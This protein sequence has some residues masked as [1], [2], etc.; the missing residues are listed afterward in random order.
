MAYRDLKESQVRRD[1]INQPNIYK[2][3]SGQLAQFV[4]NEELS[5]SEHTVHGNYKSSWLRKKPLPTF[6]TQHKIARNSKENVRTKVGFV[7]IIK[8]KKNSNSSGILISHSENRHQDTKLQ[9][10]GLQ[11]CPISSR[12]EMGRRQLK[13]T[14]NSVKQRLRNPNKY[15]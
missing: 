12:A 14:S 15:D 5:N 3:C 1:L 13:Q 4:Y 10:F 2:S 11:T 6:R 9:L 8:E 7:F